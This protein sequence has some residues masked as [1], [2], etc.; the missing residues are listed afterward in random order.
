[1]KLLTISPSSCIVV[2]VHVVKGRQYS[3]CTVPRAGT[4]IAEMDSGDQLST[5][6]VTS[7]NALI[8]HRNELDSGVQ[9]P[10]FRFGTLRYDAVGCMLYIAQG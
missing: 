7:F 6:I 2:M 8:N 1:M 5:S 10:N 3:V 4:S 9:F